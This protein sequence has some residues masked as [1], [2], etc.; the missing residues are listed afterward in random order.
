MKKLLSLYMDD[1]GLKYSDF[2]KLLGKNA[3]L[4]LCNPQY[5]TYEDAIIISRVFGMMPD[6][7]FYDDFL[8][9]NE[10]ENKVLMAKEFHSKR[11]K[12]S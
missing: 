1:Y 9:N 8:K 5:L 6:E 3:R 11:K 12:Q 7:L 2:D 4:S 10:L